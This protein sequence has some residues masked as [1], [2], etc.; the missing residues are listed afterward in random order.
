MLKKV[1][2]VEQIYN[3]VQEVFADDTF[4]NRRLIFIAVCY[5]V[6]QPLSYL[7][8]AAG[9][10]PAGVRDEM[11]RCLSFVN[12]EMVNH[13]K[14]FTEPWLKPFNTGPERPFKTKVMSIV[15]RFKAYSINAEDTQYSLGI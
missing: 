4:E 9:K 12:P 10:L 3:T 6:Y 5:Q 13:Y 8:Q 2:F 14:T 1:K 7:D 15:E 11:S